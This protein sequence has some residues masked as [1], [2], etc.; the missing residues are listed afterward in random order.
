MRKKQKRKSKYIQLVKL[1]GISGCVILAL[2]VVLILAQLFTRENQNPSNETEQTTSVQEQE[3]PLTEGRAV[4]LEKNSRNQVMLFNINTGKKATL[5]MDGS[6]CFYDKYGQA[7]SIGQLEIGE[8]VDIQYQKSQKYLHSMQQSPSAWTL[9]DVDKFTLDV[10]KG[11]ITVGKSV[12]RVTDQTQCFFDGEPVN[13][14]EISTGDVLTLNGVDQ[15]ILSIRV[16]KGHGYLKLE[17]EDVFVGGWIEIGQNIIRSIQENML[18]LVP[19]GTHQVT[20]SYRGYMDTQNV[21]IVRNQETIM[22]VGDLADSII[23]YGKVYFNVTPSDAQVYIDGTLVDTSR[24]INLEYGLHQLVAEADG[25]E[26]L[27]QYFRLEGE[28]ASLDVELQ[29]PESEEVED[30]SE[31]ESSEES[32]EEDGSSESSSASESSESGTDGSS[33]ES[34]SSTSDT[35]SSSGTEGSTSADSTEASQDS[36]ASSESTQ[37]TESS[38]EET[39][40]YK[41]HINQPEGAE[42]Y[43]DGNYVGLSPCSFKKQPGSHV[44][45]LRKTGYDT[46]SYTIQLDDEK[47]DATFNFAEFY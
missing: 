34:S 46:R 40:S 39:A 5:S 30:S 47:E 17:N 20:I 6:T 29:L 8:V 26:T 19:E 36:S 41:V 1:A 33:G 14:A 22:D 7:L 28:S 21:E 4:F 13:I 11:V 25:Y 37:S 31:E 23:K 35:E 45:T 38:S 32:D 15:Q 44:I 24:L 2:L 18:I 27:T 42:I 3:L 12:Y 16:D 10:I 9:T 43:L